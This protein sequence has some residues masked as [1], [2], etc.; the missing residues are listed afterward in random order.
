MEYT[1][2]VINRHNAELLKARVLETCKTRRKFGDLAELLGLSK[3]KIKTATD[4]LEKNNHLLAEKVFDTQVRKWHRTF[5]TTTHPYRVKSLDELQAEYDKTYTS[6]EKFGKYDALMRQNKN[7]RVHKLL[8]R[9][10]PNRT[11]VRKSQKF[12][13]IGSCF[14]MF[15]GV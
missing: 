13:G 15:D 10:R 3:G 2:V 1:D 14:A 5:T 6:P 9:A 4:F 11:G 12:V 8:D 7:L